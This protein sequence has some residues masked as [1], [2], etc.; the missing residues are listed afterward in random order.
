M[1]ISSHTKS[2]V[3]LSEHLR[4]GAF[5]Y[6]QAE[7]IGFR[8]GSL[9]GSDD[10]SGDLVAKARQGARGETGARNLLEGETQM[11]K[12]SMKAKIVV[13]LV[14]VG[15]LSL[16]GVAYAYW[17]A[18]GSGTGT[19]STGT[20]TNNLVITNVTVPA[21]VPG[22]TKPLSVNIHN[23]N[24]FSVNVNVV[25][26]TVSVTAPEDCDPTWFH[27]A[28]Q[29]PDLRVLANGDLSSP[30]TITFD[31]TTANQDSCKTATLNLTWA[32]TSH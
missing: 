16:S 23:P 7:R 2:Q 15:C 19:S 14:A 8:K 6:R 31:D 13:S 28:T 10:L 21:L 9:S 3:R 17:T 32:S 22:D 18:G 29:T 1:L 5:A 20:S 11:R 27:V 24:S 4:R 26:A 30:T 25:S 12:L